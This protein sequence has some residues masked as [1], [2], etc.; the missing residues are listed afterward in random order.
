MPTVT[1]IAH[2]TLKVKNNYRSKASRRFQCS[3]IGR[4]LRTSGKS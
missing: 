4:T 2:K 1:T 3:N